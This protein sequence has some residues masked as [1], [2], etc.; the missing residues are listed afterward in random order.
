MNK[1]LPLELFLKIMLNCYIAIKYFNMN[2]YKI[3]DVLLY[4]IR[5]RL[6]HVD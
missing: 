4:S 2:K 1:A 3:Y 6:F 5:C